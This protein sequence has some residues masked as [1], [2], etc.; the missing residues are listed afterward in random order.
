MVGLPLHMWSIKVF[1]KIGD[2]CRGFIVVDE[3]TVF[4][5]ELQWTRILVKLESK[6]FPSSLEIV[7]GLHCFSVQLWWETHPY[8]V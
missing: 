3:N 7:V 2:G 8:F 6:E 4:F 1:K 5:M